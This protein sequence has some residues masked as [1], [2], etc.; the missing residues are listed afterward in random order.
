MPPVLRSALKTRK[1][2][3]YLLPLPLIAGRDDR[4]LGARLGAEEGGSLLLDGAPAPAPEHA[5][6]AAEE[7]RAAAPQV[8]YPTLPR[9][10]PGEFGFTISTA[11]P[12][13]GGLM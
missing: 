6:A 8:Q 13:V 4:G 12:N 5:P 10:G 3:G 9:T 2:W 1:E 7:R 11:A